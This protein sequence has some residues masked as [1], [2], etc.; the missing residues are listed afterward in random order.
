MPD[1][2]LHEPRYDGTTRADWSPPAQA[3]FEGDALAAIDDHFL[4][5]TSGFEPDAFDDLSLAVVEPHGEL[6]LDALEAAHEQAATLDG[7]DERTAEDAETLAR[8]LADEQ[9][10]QSLD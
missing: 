2:T 4:L 3:D 8:R 6:N 7:I 1:Y 5:S 10:D 9:F